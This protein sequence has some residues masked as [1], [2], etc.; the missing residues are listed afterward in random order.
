MFS[1]T[2]YIVLFIIKRAL[3]GVDEV[4][5]T[6]SE[7]SESGVLERRVEIKT[8]YREIEKLAETFNSML[9][10]IQTL[11]NELKE[12]N[13]NIAHDLKTPITRIR[14]LAEVTLTGR[15]STLEDYENLASD[16]IEESDNLLE[17]ITSMLYISKA[18]AGIS[19]IV[20]DEI[21]LSEIIE[22][23]C[24]LFLPVAEEKGII[25]N[26]SLPES[27]MFYGEQKSIQ[28]M[29]SNLLDNAVKYSSDKGSV[30]I[31]LRKNETDIIIRISDTGAGI[32]EDKIKYIF[33]RFYSCH[34]GSNISGAGLGLSMVNSIV[35]QHSGKISVESKLNKGTVFIVTLPVQ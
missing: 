35:K 32:P 10:S 30:N 20:K 18:D 13:D 1:F 3:R 28:R 12:I 14:G 25:I 15:N 26:L 9:N 7:I 11:V 5:K 24:D 23:A 6:A 34:E 16:T 29:I 17:I 2:A 27:C 4:A 8:G 19:R 33:K 22:T 31:S 21:N